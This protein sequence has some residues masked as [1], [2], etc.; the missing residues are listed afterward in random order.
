MLIKH[1]NL[2]NFMSH[3][4]T[5]ISLPSTGVVVLTGLNGSGKSTLPE[6]VAYAAWGKTLRGT[7]PWTAGLAGSVELF[8]DY[9]T[10]KRSASAKGTNKLAW[11]IPDQE[12]EEFDTKTQSQAHLKSVLV[13][14]DLWRR[15]HVFSS[16]DAAHF[17]MAT[18]KE[19]KQLIEAVL[20]LDAFDR[21]LAACRVDKAAVSKD[22]DALSREHTQIGNQ[23]AGLRIARE[24]WTGVAPFDPEPE[25]TAP[26]EPDLM[27]HELAKRI[28]EVEDLLR[29]CSVPINGMAVEEARA[30]WNV[31]YNDRRVVES[32]LVLVM[33][34]QCPTCS[35]DFEA[36]LEETTRAELHAQVFHCSELEKVCADAEAEYTLRAEARRKEAAAYQEQLQALRIQLGEANASVRLRESWAAQHAAWAERTAA[37]LAQWRALEAEALAKRDRL[38]AG[39]SE[40]TDQLAEQAELLAAAE[41][42]LRELAASEQVLGYR[43]VR[44]QVLVSAL[45][46]IEELANGWLSMMAPDCS[47]KL[48]PY[49]ETASGGVSDA[50]DLQITGM[51]G[52]LGYKAASA[53]ERR[54]IDA[55]LLLA[56]AD[57]AAAASGCEND[58]TL[59]MD[60]VF[61]ALD[62]DG[63]A[64]VADCLAEIGLRRAIVVITHR[65]ELAS[66]L[67]AVKRLHV[68]DGVLMELP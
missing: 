44:V 17:S 12:T 66:Y 43:G 34:G 55:A 33:K 23:L 35:R 3:G 40:L 8:A 30:A 4:Q 20:G 62:A 26:D 52:G 39:I 45:A 15:T 14:M 36:G 68:T 1:L 2:T 22:W 25:P 65:P 32:E 53:G 57:V 9:V 41:A 49:T 37:R 10:V 46:A 58:G 60:E 7:R 48:Q 51:G 61:D 13:D 54:R 29:A 18:D 16:A 31:A 38:D 28:G 56:L 50:L 19:R 27:P 63:C 6:A 59:W 67:P 47:L 5:S 11:S 42:R 64:L 24:Q 21:A